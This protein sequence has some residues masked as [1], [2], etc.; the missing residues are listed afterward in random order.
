MTHFQG[1]Q[2]LIIEDDQT[3]INVLQRLLEQ[4][5]VA[6]AVIHDNINIADQ[7]R[8]VSP[9]DVIFLDLEMPLSNGYTVLEILQDDP[10]FDGVPVVAYTTHTS[11]MNDARRAG[12]HSFLGKPLDSNQFPD[13]LACILNGESVWEVS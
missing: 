7:L 8:H 10:T 2:A 9:P 5:Q 11:H 13:Q 3:S 12:F 4:L 1:A 6:T